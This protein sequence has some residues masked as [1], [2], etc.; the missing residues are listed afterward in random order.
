M[1]KEKNSR[2]EGCRKRG[3]RTTFFT[4]QQVQ[5]AVTPG[6]LKKLGLILTAV[7]GAL[8]SSTLTLPRLLLLLAT[9]AGMA[10]SVLTI[11]SQ[12][13]SGEKEG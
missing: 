4:R 12:T 11:L 7:S 9:V 13:N 2:K 10:G 3:F 6:R 8:L 1:K 5:K